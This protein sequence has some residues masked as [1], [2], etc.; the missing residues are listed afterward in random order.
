MKVTHLKFHVAQELPQKR[1][2]EDD[3]QKSFSLL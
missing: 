3:E 1:E 2:A